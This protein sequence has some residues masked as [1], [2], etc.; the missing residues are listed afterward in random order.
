MRRSPSSRSC[1]PA[2]GVALL[3][4]A[5]AG[6]LPQGHASE[7]QPHADVGL[8]EAWPG[9]VFDAPTFCVSDGSDTTM[10]IGEQTGRI[11]QIA[12]YRG[13]GDVPQPTNFLDLSS[14]VHAKMQ[15]G[16]LGCAFHPQYATNNRLYVSFLI[17][18]PGTGEQAFTLRVAEYSAP[19]G[20]CDPASEAVVLDIPKS[21]AIHQG[22]GLGFGPDGMLYLGVGDGGDKVDG[23]TEGKTFPSQNPQN[24]LGKI[25]RVDVSTPGKG[26]PA[27]DNPWATQKGWMPFIWAYGFRNPFQFAWDANGRMWTAEP[28]TKGPG[29]REWVTE[30]RRGGNHGWPFFEGDRP[31]AKGD[32]PGCVMPVHVYDSTD[33]AGAAVAGKV[34]RG[35]R[36]PGLAGRFIFLDHMRGAIYSLD[37][38]DGTAKDWRLVGSIPDPSAV[39]EDAQGELFI[40]SFG[41]GKIFTAVGK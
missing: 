18:G 27:K 8:V 28:G 15:G 1:L 34:Y 41:Q 6:G 14:K 23:T 31:L 35:R 32:A 36:V 26:A 39:G 29:S 5:A 13:Q 12:K 3:A 17:Q 21:R 16:L 7:P 4:L 24:P 2:L 33:K 40:A 25:L 11:K 10:F 20:V 38:R 37:L 30:V 19:G 9:V 22:G